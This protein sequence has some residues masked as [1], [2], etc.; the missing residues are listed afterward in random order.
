MVEKQEQIILV[1]EKEDK[2]AAMCGSDMGLAITG[3]ILNEVAALHLPTIALNYQ[4]SIQSYFTSLYGQYDSDVNIVAKGEI[5]PE[6]W[7]GR[8]GYYLFI[9][10]FK[11]N[12]IYIY[13]ILNK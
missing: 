13:D 11:Y 5:F 6:K 8:G 2:W 12:K 7:T 9:N 4:S 10:H 1:T 3:D